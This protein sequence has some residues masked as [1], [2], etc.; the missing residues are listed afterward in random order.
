MSAIRRVLLFLGI[1]KSRARLYWDF[2]PCCQDD[3]RSYSSF[4]RCCQGLW[5][6]SNGCSQCFSS[7]WLRW[8]GYMRVP[9]G[10]SGVSPGQVC[11][12]RK[13]ALW[14][15][16][17]AAELVLQ[18]CIRSSHLRLHAE[19][20]RLLS[21]HSASAHGV[22][23]RCSS[24]SMILLLPAMT[25]PPSLTSSGIWALVSI[26]KTLVHLSTF[27]VLKLLVTPRVCFFLNASTPWIFCLKPVFLGLSPLIFLWNKTTSL[28]R[29][30]V[31]CLM[32]RS[33]IA[34]SWVVSSIWPLRGQS[35]A[36]PSTFLL[37]SCSTRR[38]LIGRPLFVFFIILKVIRAKGLFLSSTSSSHYHC[39][40]RLRLGR[41]PNYSP[42]HLPGSSSSLVTL[43]SLGRRRSKLPSLA[44]L[45]RLN[46]VLWLPPVLSYFGSSPCS[47]LLVF[48]LTSPMHLFC[49]SQAAL[50]I[51][52]NPVFHERTKHIEIDLSF[53][54]WYHSGRHVT[55]SHI[56]TVS[57][58]RG[59]LHQ[60]LGKHQFQH[61]LSQVGHSWSSCSN[62]RGSI[63]RY[64]LYYLIL[65]IPY[66]LVAWA[67]RC[68]CIYVKTISLDQSKSS[69]YLFQFYFL[70]NLSISIQMS[71]SN[72][73]MFLI[74]RVE[75]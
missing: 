60:G 36:T 75:Y 22:L 5:A 7:W 23:Y 54:S 18:A 66:L 30:R 14:S 44:P 71:N 65:Y 48:V 38:T 29:L 24:M 3:Y 73:D 39:L 13:V 17:G 34:A 20:C 42:L 47:P 62:L 15:S 35:C 12:L 4:C 41:M 19:L 1:V 50:H 53:C 49:D 52:A 21:V 61:L 63:R 64:L 58:T 27:L 26:W 51:A 69:E 74:I 11:R 8:G 70:S 16:S 55:T 25:L 67:P 2:C 9:Q 72:K 56:P 37:S 43:R 28:P 10:L 33:G 59:Y 40:L 45:L 32:N 31:R 68:L 6:S 46:I 57:S